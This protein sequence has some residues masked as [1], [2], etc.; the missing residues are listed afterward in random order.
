METQ[1]IIETISPSLLKRI[2]DSDWLSNVL[3]EMIESEDQTR[4]PFEAVELARVAIINEEEVSEK[5]MEALLGPPQF[6]HLMDEETT[7]RA[8]LS[9]LVEEALR[10][11]MGLLVTEPTM[12]Y[13]RFLKYYSRTDR[14]KDYENTGKLPDRFRAKDLK[15]PPYWFCNYFEV[16]LY[17]SPIEKSLKE[18]IKRIKST[19]GQQEWLL[20]AIKPFESDGERMSKS[21]DI[22]I[23]RSLVRI[24]VAFAIKQPFET[25]YHDRVRPTP[26]TNMGGAK[27]FFGY[28][29]PIDIL[30]PRRGEGLQYTEDF[31]FLARFLEQGDKERCE[32]KDEWYGKYVFET[33]DDAQEFITECELDANIDVLTRDEALERLV[34]EFWKFRDMVRSQR[35]NFLL[36]INGVTLKDHDE[37]PQKA[38]WEFGAGLLH[39]FFPDNDPIIENPKLIRFYQWDY[40]DPEVLFC[41]LCG[42]I[43][44]PAQ[45]HY[46]SSPA[47][48]RS[49][50]GREEKLTL[51]PHCLGEFS[52]DTLK[53]N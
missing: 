12:D 52:R 36:K 25:C 35:S 7:K 42:P 33:R 22:D 1:E 16:P 40:T 4:L 48:W 32:V 6:K 34:D 47:S 43:A 41:P 14:F 46:R 28:I 26:N 19:P 44:E 30:E 23:L 9:A 17:I 29:P 37:E 24:A 2:L 49:H 8:R 20:D 13:N 45:A 11:H 50:A 53:M 15:N 18:E 27:N 39:P 3:L 51:C 38:L 31:P 10:Q 21:I 5:E